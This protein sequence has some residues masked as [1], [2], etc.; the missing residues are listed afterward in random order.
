MNTVQQLAGLGQSI[1][2]DN[3]ER[4]LLDNGAMAGMIARGE[5]RGVT[6]NPSIF[7]NA[8]T[9]TGDYDAGLLPLIAAG[10]DAPAIFWELA[11]EDIRAA[12]DLFRPLYDETNGGDGY[13]S[14]EVNPD[15]AHDTAATLA[16]TKTLWRRV[17][18]PNLMIKIPATE[19]G[20][21]AIRAAIAAGINVNVTLIFARERYRAVMD[22][23]LSG[24]EDRV[25][26]G[27]PIDGIASVASF[28]VSRVDSN[29]DKKL[30][31][32]IKEGGARAA[33][34]EALLGRAAIA[35]ARLAYADFRQVFGDERFARLRAAGGRVQRPLWASTGTKNP[36]YSDVVY[37]DELVGPDTVNTVPPQ[38]LAALLDHG[39][40]RPTLEQHIAEARRVEAELEGLGISLAEV[41]ADLER[42]GVQSFKD[43]FA[44]LLAAVEERRRSAVA[45]D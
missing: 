14:L 17:D 1:W 2:Y 9:K 29:V 18:R 4:G 30:Q 42:E 28:F 38:T 43:A 44:T 32:I 33:A 19:A 35:N 37:V 27:Q 13:V 45:A 10:H 24:L 15:L 26:A 11:I 8:I 36:A 3:I 34:A 6:S 23:Y 39:V 16:E 5:I 31:G 41:T 25:A 12:T 22:A 20:I 21:P 40:A 7:L